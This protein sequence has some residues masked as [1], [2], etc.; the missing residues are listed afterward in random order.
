MIFS[1]PK[2]PNITNPRIKST[3]Q[4][5]SKWIQAAPQ[6]RLKTEQ[7]GQECVTH[8]YE[9]RDSRMGA[10]PKTVENPWVT[11]LICVTHAF[12]SEPNA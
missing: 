2:C 6:S 3:A 5:D 12:Q 10:K 1:P 7:V 4:R 8:A 9:M 11:H